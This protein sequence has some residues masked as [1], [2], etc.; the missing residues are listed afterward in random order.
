[1]SVYDEATPYVAINEVRRSN[2]GSA[3]QWERVGKYQPY[4]VRPFVIEV[5]FQAIYGFGGLTQ[6]GSLIIKGQ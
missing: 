3:I 4:P 5:R 6:T 1:M 2:R